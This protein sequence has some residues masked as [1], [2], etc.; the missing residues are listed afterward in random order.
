MC[1]CVGLTVHKIQ[2]CRCAQPKSSPAVFKNCIEDTVIDTIDVVGIV[3]KVSKC[4]CSPVKSIKSLSCAYPNNAVIVFLNYAYIIITY[5][6]LILR[7]MY[8]M[9]DYFFVC[10]CLK[11]SV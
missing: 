11:H 7:I 4:L 8:I 2:A 6:S 9:P 10:V 3:F 5:A 1:K